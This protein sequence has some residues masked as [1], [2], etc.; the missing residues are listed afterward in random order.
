[1]RRPIDRR[2]VLFG[3]EQRTGRAIERVAEAVAIE[4]NQRLRRLSFD[5]DVGEDHFVH[6][7]EVPL[8]VRRHLI[9]PLRHS[10]VQIAGEYRHRPFVVARALRRI[11]RRR[12]AGAVVDQVQALVVAV[13]A[14]G[15]A[16]AGLPLIALPGLER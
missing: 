7:V 4:V 12:I 14:P 3:D 5:V 8:V 13:P 9:R 6:A 1:M 10:G 2:I 16:A 11:P 15:R